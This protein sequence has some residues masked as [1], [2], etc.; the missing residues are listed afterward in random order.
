MRLDDAFF[1]RPTLDVASGLVG[2]RLIW[3]RHRGIITEVEAYIGQADPA[4]HAA[5]GMTKRTQAMF[6]PPGR[7]YVY[8]IYGMYWCL[9]IVTEAEGFPAAVLIRALWDEHERRY[10]KGPGILCREFGIT[11]ADYGRDITCEPDIG[12][13]PRVAVL[14]TEYTPRIGIRVGTEHLWR[15]VATKEAITFL[16]AQPLRALGD[17]G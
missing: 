14:A 16:K 1:E 6:G 11:G 5:K 10:L 17:A 8:F 9:N 12:I 4:C 2:C 15:V 7:V 13:E 3:G